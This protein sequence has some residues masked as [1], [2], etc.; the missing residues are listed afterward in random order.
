MP[1]SSPPWSPGCRR[2]VMAVTHLSG[3][4]SSATQC[5]MANCNS[6]RAPPLMIVSACGAG[7]P[8]SPSCAFVTS[9]F[10]HTV[11]PFALRSAWLEWGDWI[12]MTAWC[13]HLCGTSWSTAP[14]PGRQ[15]RP[16]ST[17][18]T[19]LTRCPHCLAFYARTFGM[20][21]ARISLN[22]TLPKVVTHRIH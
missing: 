17:R 13:W 9:I 4:G 18:S 3:S 6:P 8:E 1:S 20:P 22:A 15:N 7:L 2:T 14:H 12:L 5:H 10:P 11:H 16:T 19:S 21:C